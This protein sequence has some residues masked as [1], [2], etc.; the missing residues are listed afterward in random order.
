MKRHAKLSPCGLYRYALSRVWEPAKGAVLFVMLNPSTADH[1]ADDPTIRKCI[2]FARRWGFGAL[3]VVN[4]FA[5]R[6]T[7]PGNLRRAQKLGIDIVGD[8]NKDAIGDAVVASNQVVLAWGANAES[9]APYARTV[10]M[11][12]RS[13]IRDVV[14]LGT[15]KDGHPRHPLMLA[16]STQREAAKL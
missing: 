14:C 3:H 7:D 2:G 11:G 5:Y 8:L 6:A 10:A 4:L 13:G 15:S 12:I 1:E 9:W 16:Y